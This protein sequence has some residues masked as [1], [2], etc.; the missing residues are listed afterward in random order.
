M[1]SEIGLQ[2]SRFATVRRAI[3]VIVVLVAWAVAVVGIVRDHTHDSGAST[4]Y[5][6]VEKKAPAKP[7]Y[8][9][10]AATPV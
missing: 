2:K 6:G 1:N 5:P 3:L 8:A 7:Y 10:L 9:F 4:A